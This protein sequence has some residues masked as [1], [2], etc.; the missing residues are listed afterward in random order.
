MQHH[1][2]KT[3]KNT[4]VSDVFIVRYAKMQRST[5]VMTLDLRK[6]TNYAKN[7][8]RRRDGGLLNQDRLQPVLLA[9]PGRAR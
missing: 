2:N 7:V 8:K 5:L 6:R 4:L 9:G 1:V 3:A